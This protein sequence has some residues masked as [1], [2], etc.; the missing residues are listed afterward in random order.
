MC[1]DKAMTGHGTV[2]EPSLSALLIAEDR[3]LAASLHQALASARVFEVMSELRSYPTEQTLEMRLRQV[4]PDV[5]LLDVASNFEAASRL[6]RVI[7][8]LTKAPPVVALHSSNDSGVLVASLRAG[9]HEFLYSPFETTAQQASAARVRRL[10]EPEPQEQRETGKVVAFSSAKPGSGA[11]TL[12]FRRP[13][14][15]AGQRTS[16][17]CWADFDVLSGSVAFGLK[18]KPAY[19]LLDVVERVEEFEPGL[20][21]EVTLPCGGVDVL[22]APDS[23]LNDSVE[24]SRLHDTLEHAR[25]VYDWVIVDL[26][27]V[28]RR[29]SLFVASEAD[30]SYIVSTSELPSL[31]LA[32]R[33]VNMLAQLN[34]EAS[35]FHMVVNRMARRSEISVPDMEKVFGCRVY[36]TFPNDYHALHRVVTRAEPLG[37]DCELGRS[38]E[39]FFA[40]RHRRRP[41]VAGTDRGGLRR[42]VRR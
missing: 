9:A 23:A 26:P 37:P 17:C 30:Q 40:A 24:F 38:I 35:R 2:R 31:H 20:W 7:A 41:A 22:A 19:S 21:P 18:L 16:V 8:G 6:I 42:A 11:T 33:A 39:Q 12:P 13:F 15:C 3:A 4:Q 34:F 1:S 10:R 5:V 29:M 36:H 25:T 27:T 32:R 14:R 28:F